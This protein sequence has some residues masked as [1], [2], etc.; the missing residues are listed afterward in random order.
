MLC[1]IFG[2]IIGHTNWQ[3]YP[4]YI[5]LGTMVFKIFVAGTERSIRVLSGNKALILN[6]RIPK[7]LYVLQAVYGA[8]VDFLISIIILVGVM[9][10]T[11]VGTN[12]MCLLVIPDIMIL[13][14]LITGIGKILAVINVY[15]ADIK[16][17]YDIFTLAV[18]YGSALFANPSKY[19]PVMQKIISFNP[20]YDA[21]SIARVSVIDMKMPGIGLWIKLVS[22][23]IIVY[24]IGYFV[25]K[26]GT[27]NVVAKL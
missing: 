11:G 25:F 26:R 10:Y 22:S 1:L 3:A 13:L 15:F 7:Q 12:Y 27:E 14:V 18:F 17:F 19:G 4:V 20:I 2:H 24:T 6:T 16:Y 21:I 23:A 5:L 8:L 9:I